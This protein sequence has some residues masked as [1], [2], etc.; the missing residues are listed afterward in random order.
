MKEFLAIIAIIM[1]LLYFPLQNVLD[2]ANH[3]RINSLHQIVHSASQKARIEGKFTNEIVQEMTSNIKSKFSNIS[4]SE[5]DISV[6]SNTVYRLPEFDEKNVIKYK[7]S[8]P[9][10]KLLA[11]NG[12]L[13]VSD[14][15]NKTMYTVEGY[16]LSELLPVSEGWGS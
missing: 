3:N 10:K 12:F 13:G 6:T 2:V 9:I 14:E 5:I 16:V 7:I 4:E 8:V 1:I 15:E 11:M